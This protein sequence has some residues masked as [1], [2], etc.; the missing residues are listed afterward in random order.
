ML[1]LVMRLNHEFNPATHWLIRLQ[2]EGGSFDQPADDLPTIK[3]LLFLFNYF[4][5]AIKTTVWIHK[6][7]R[8]DGDFEEARKITC[9][10]LKIP[11]I[12][13]G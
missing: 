8:Q 12:M 6:Y 3:R 1:K 2:S 9:S 5:E 13:A 7:Q 10:P 11:L 4:K